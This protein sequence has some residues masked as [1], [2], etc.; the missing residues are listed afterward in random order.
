MGKDIITF[1]DI[2]TEKNEF[3]HHKSPIFLKRCTY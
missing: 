2:E 1:G 3:Y